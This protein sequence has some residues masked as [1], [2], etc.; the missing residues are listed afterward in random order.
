VGA[1]T[2]ELDAATATV[3]GFICNLDLNVNMASITR[4]YHQGQEKLRKLESLRNEKGL[5]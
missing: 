5:E 4:S 1:T 3:N 2:P